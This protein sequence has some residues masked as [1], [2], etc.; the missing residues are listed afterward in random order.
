MFKEGKRATSA[1][2]FCTIFILLSLI[3]NNKLD[4]HSQAR[5]PL[6]ELE[7]SAPYTKG[8]RKWRDLSMGYGIRTAS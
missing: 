7:V 1:L 4:I 6:L 3:F 5:V 2:W 8:L